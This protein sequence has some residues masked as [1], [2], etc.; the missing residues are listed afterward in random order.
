[1]IVLLVVY[2][3][4]SLDLLDDSRTDDSIPPDTSSRT[5][6]VG[7]NVLEYTDVKLL[8]ADDE[9]RL[10][11]EPSSDDSRLIEGQAGLVEAPTGVLVDLCP[12]CNDKVSGYHYGLQT[13][14]SC[15]GNCC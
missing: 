5:V 1:M 14:E 4:G 11:V 6:D 12:V 15:K 10:L 2:L 13:C 3:A 8:K 9:N 7:S